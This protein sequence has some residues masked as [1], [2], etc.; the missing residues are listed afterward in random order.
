M[1]IGAMERGYLIAVIGGVA[2][3]TATALVGGRSEPWDSGLYWS[4]SYPLSLVAAAVL[5]Y[6]FPSRPW[7]WALVLMYS[8]VLVMLASG[9]GLGLL[10]L[11]LILL[12]MLSL[13]AIALARAGAF[14][15][16]RVG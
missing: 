2:L 12:G 4:V 16:L 11:G 1:G 5:G 8:Q 10:P 13:P 3:W 15:R 9:S 7:R 6:V 14:A